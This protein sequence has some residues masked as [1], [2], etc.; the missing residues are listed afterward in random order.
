VS[1]AVIRQT[2]YVILKPNASISKAMEQLALQYDKGITS[3]NEREP[4]F[5]SKLKTLFRMKGDS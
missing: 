3:N 1:T 5:L 4:A 2:P